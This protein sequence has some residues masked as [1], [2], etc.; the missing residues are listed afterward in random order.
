MHFDTVVI[1][2][3]AG[4]FGGP[5]RPNPTGYIGPF[6]TSLKMGAATCGA[7]SYGPISG[8]VIA[9]VIDLLLYLNLL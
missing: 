2:I 9:R 1:I 5:A 3:G 7:T 6:D 4:P 8:H